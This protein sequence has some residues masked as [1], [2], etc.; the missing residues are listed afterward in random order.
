MDYINTN[1]AIIITMQL[2]PFG[3]MWVTCHVYYNIMGK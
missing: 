3:L 1:L 2:A